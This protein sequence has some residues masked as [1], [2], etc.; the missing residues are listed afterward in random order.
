MLAFAL[1]HPLTLFSSAA[2]GR[3]KKGL[4]SKSFLD[5][6]PRHNG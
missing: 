5:S 2:K 6:F 1:T 3:R 4:C